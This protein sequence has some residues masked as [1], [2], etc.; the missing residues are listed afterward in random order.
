MQTEP[1]L[2]AIA[3]TLQG[4]MRSLAPMARRL[5]TAGAR[6]LW[7]GDYFQSGLVRAAVLGAATVNASVG[8]HVLQAFA[9]SPL[10]TALAATDL[11]ELTGGRFVLGLGSQFPAANRRWHGVAVERPVA[12]LREYV[13][14]VRTLLAASGGESVSFDGQQFGYRVPPFRGATALP[15]PPVWV[16]GAGPAM[17][18]LAAEV[19][20]GLAGHL[21]WTYAHVRD[22]VRPVLGA[23]G[24][25]LTVPRLVGS[26]AVPGAHADVLRALAH[27]IVTPGYEK[28]LVRQDIDLDRARLLAAVRHHDAKTISRLVEPYAGRWCIRDAAELA[29]HQALAAAHGVDQLMLLVP[30]G[31]ADPARVEVHER[32]L[33]DLLA[34]TSPAGAAS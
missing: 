3:V 32:A 18:R 11:Q 7:A 14:A 8:T 25:P 1:A 21:L 12:A 22:E 17:V 29:R 27:Y 6:S 30:G 20:D 26:R 4:P 15:P 33:A 10:A 31:A 34:V 16:G 9:R 5:E 23:C 13:A 2:A 19:A 28:L 24:I